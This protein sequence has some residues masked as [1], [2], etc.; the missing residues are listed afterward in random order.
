M[1]YR[2]EWNNKTALIIFHGAMSRQEL[3]DAG[4]AFYADS[5]LDT[6]EC[7]IADFSNVDLSQ[8]TFDDINTIASIDS[9]TV[10]YKPKLKMAFVVSDDSVRD[11]L[12]KYIDTSKNLSSTWNYSVYD[13]REDAQNWCQI[14]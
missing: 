5:R 7:L 9:I 12:K 8:L 6:L 11:A 10:Q 14:A 13:K 2:L 1:P 4:N 3:R